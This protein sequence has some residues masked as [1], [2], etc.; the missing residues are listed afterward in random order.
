MLRG[1]IL[2]SAAA[3]FAPAQSVWPEMFAG[4]KR[5]ATRP[6]SLDERAVWEEYGLEV[7]QLAA[8][9]SEAGTFQ[10]TAYRLKDPTGAMGVF[11]W[12]RPAGA[13][14]S[15]VEK[16]AVE[17]DDGVML[18]YGNYVLDFH[19]IRPEADD[20]AV[21]LAFLPRLD[22]SALPPV[23]SYLP[24]AGRIANSERF[25][26]GPATLEKF[27]GKVPPSLVAFHTG[28]EGQLGRFQAKG[29]DLELAVIS[30]PTPHVARERL[31]QF[32]KIPGAMAKRS[33]P[34]VAVILSPPDRDD[35]ERLLALVTYRATI[36]WN[37]GTPKDEGN[38]GDLLLAIFALTG[39]LLVGALMMG[40]LMGG[41]RVIGRKWLGKSEDP[42]TLLHL[43]DR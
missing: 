28:A 19:G 30:F 23:T 16:L 39:L 11:Q 42:M 20:L 9:E 10:A 29:G 18:A 6:V 15:K 2:V 34:L 41:F 12:M 35:A 26:M 24:S 43:E 27:W 3:A 13:R 8:Y 33:G 14:P 1:L 5:A 25:V 4:Y 38:V 17:T 36:S 32:E 7:A 21:L 31:A 40:F 37:E 22:Q